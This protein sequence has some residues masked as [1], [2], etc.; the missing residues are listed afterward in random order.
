MP[1]PGSLRALSILLLLA[2]GC[3]PQGPHREHVEV[4][5]ALD[6]LRVPLPPAAPAV[7]ALGARLFAAPSPAAGSGFAC[8]S[9]HDLAKHGQDQRRLAVAGDTETP[10]RNTP[11]VFDSARQVLQGWDGV[12][13]DLPGIVRRELEL[14][15]GVR[16]DATVR[17]WLHDPAHRQ[18]DLAEYFAL[19]FPGQPQGSLDQVV[20]AL[21]AHLATLRSVGRWDR[22]VEGD[23]SALSAEERAGVRAFLDAGCATCHAGRN[24]GG[25]SAHKLGL[26]HAYPSADPGRFLRTRL[27]AD[28]FVFKAPM[29]RRVVHT[30]PY[31][32]DGSIESLAEVVRRMAWHELGRTLA[33]DVVGS[34]LKFLQAVGDVDP[35][36]R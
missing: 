11:T 21:C 24:L 36:G 2:T 29:L 1:P 14:R 15:L 27:P 13:T 34:I 6:A 3:G 28:E 20:T 12:A 16:T 9:C 4:L 18:P 8:A 17:L 19:A 30:A 26:V 33:P 10:R 22:Y 5:F 7:Q 31:L 35:S 32:H 25:A 23:E